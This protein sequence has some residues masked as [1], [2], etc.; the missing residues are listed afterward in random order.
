MSEL[1]AQPE[2]IDLARADDLRD[3]V[4]RAVACLAQGGIVALPTET[5]YALAASALHPAA[6]AGLGRIKGPP[7]DRPLPLALR[8]PAEVAD[9]VPGA[10]VVASRLASRSWPGA[11]TLV[12]HGPLQRGLA[13]RLPPEV[14]RRVAADD[15]IGLRCPAHPLVRDILEFVPGPLVLTGARRNGR[16]PTLSAEPLGTLSRIDMILDEGPIEPGEPSTVVRVVGGEWQVIRPGTVPEAEIGRRTGLVLLFVCTGNTCR[17]PM[18]EALCRAKI[19]RRLGCAIDEVEAQGYVVM[20][21]GVGA[22]EGMPAASHAAE[23]VRDR[24]GSLQEH[25]SRRINAQLARAADWVIALTRGHR[26]AL[27]HHLPELAGRLRLLH[28]SGEDIDDPIGADLETY[29]RTADE[30]EEHLDALLDELG[31]HPPK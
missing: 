25:S 14:G 3:V 15:W 16:R 11:V 27:L 7:E 30:I 4:H 17:S 29:R 10:S 22:M 28:A 23:V 12:L 20:S 8:G 9:W 24:G 1:D 6:V 13:G 19:A 18:A 21:A 5:A 31:I 26:E 2:W